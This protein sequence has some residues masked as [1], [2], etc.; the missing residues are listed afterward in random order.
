MAL[1]RYRWPPLVA[2]VSALE[3][4][5]GHAGNLGRPAWD[6]DRRNHGRRR[7]H[8][9]WSGRASLGN[10]PRRLRCPGRPSVVDSGLPR[11]PANG[12]GEKCAVVGSRARGL[13]R[14]TGRLCVGHGGTDRKLRRHVSRREPCFCSLRR[15]PSHRAGHRLWLGPG[16][17]RSTGRSAPPGRGDGELPTD[18][19]NG[20]GA[21]GKNQGRALD[22]L[23]RQ[24]MTTSAQ[25]PGSVRR[26]LWIG[27]RSLRAS[28]VRTPLGRDHL[29]APTVSALTRLAEQRGVALPV[30][31]LALLIVSALVT[32]FVV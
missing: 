21:F 6:D 14:P 7:H 18:D 17:R 5:Y 12:A 31:L 16:L 28:S 29:K 27:L 30:A 19:G 20:D 32:G 22:Q 4:A 15:V 2:S 1:S 25:P 10:S 3:S 26:R 23:H 9:R 13:P 24:A 11:E 8:R